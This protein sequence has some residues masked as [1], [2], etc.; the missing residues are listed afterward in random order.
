MCRAHTRSIGVSH[1]AKTTK[2]NS[3]RDDKTLNPV[4]ITG[5]EPSINLQDIIDIV[6]SSINVF[7]TRGVFA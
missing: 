1:A 7:G 2:Q 3:W 5:T 4:M 6:R